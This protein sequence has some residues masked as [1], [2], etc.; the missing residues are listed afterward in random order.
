MFSACL[1]E[2]TA[3]N[4]SKAGL[5]HLPGNGSSCPGA[6]QQQALLR[7]SSAQPQD[8]LTVA[9]GDA[10]P[11]AITSWEG[12][13]TVRAGGSPTAGPGSLPSLMDEHSACSPVPDSWKHCTH[14]AGPQPKALLPR[15]GSCCSWSSAPHQREGAARSCDN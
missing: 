11:K 14:G 3:A 6:W 5:C 7:A 2:E 12:S 15:T 10:V 13:A 9:Q 8:E 1:G 4:P